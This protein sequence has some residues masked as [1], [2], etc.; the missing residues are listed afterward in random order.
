MELAKGY[1][2]LTFA[3]RVDPETWSLWR[4]YV[5]CMTPGRAGWIFARLVARFYRASGYL[6]FMTGVSLIVA[7][8]CALSGHMDLFWM[9]YLP[10]AIVYGILFGWL[11][12]RE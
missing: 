7:G 3:V 6:G 9:Y 10:Q 5:V 2:T 1:R 8:A 11:E 12:G 4:Y